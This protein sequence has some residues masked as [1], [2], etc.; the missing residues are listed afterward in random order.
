V[1][2]IVPLYA[3]WPLAHAWAQ[4]TEHKIDRKSEAL[5]L[6]DL[7]AHL[8]QPL[9]QAHLAITLRTEDEIVA[10]Y[11]V[12]HTKMHLTFKTGKESPALTEMAAPNPD[13]IRLGLQVMAGQIVTQAVR[14]QH[15]HR[16]YRLQTGKR[17][18]WT[19][20]LDQ[21]WF[22]RAN[23][24]LL[25]NLDYGTQVSRTQIDK[26]VTAIRAY[27][28]SHGSAEGETTKPATTGT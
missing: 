12:H 15:L 10:D 19:T 4:A 22:K 23:V 17:I 16:R 13:G 5:R 27:A 24:T 8:A 20:Y 6:T 9:R 28:E 14:P 21:F 2:C 25:L 3:G 11:H 1:I 18:E 7:Q 26:I